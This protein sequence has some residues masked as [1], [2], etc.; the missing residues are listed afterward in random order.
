MPVI[1]PVCAP[2]GVYT[3]R[4]CGAFVR[5]WCVTSHRIHGNVVAP[6]RVVDDGIHASEQELALPHHSCRVIFIG[7]HGC[8]GLDCMGWIA[9]V[10]TL[11]S[12]LNK[13]SPSVGASSGAAAC[14]PS[15]SIGNR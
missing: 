6:I 10:L 5:V 8:I 1:P 9:W 12:Q 11:H 13:F 2:R 4:E 7:S 14:P 3:W 15:A